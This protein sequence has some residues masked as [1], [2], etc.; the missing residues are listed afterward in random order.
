M[1]GWI[2]LHRDIM[3]H[4][5][6]EDKPFSKGQAFID[7]LLLT[8]AS[9]KK[10]LYRGEIVELKRGDVNRSIQ[11]LSIRWG[12][13][14]GKTKRFLNILET[15][16]MITV[17]SDTKRTV[18]TVENYSRYQDRRTVDDTANDTTDGHQTVQQA[19]IPKKVKKVKNVKNN[20]NNIYYGEFENVALS[21][22][23]LEKLKERFPYDWQERIE[24][25]SAY[26][27]STG[28][29]YKSHYA[30]ILNWAR[31]EKTGEGKESHKPD[32]MDL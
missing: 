28:K 29:R 17:K 11:E 23:E 4:W 18:I 8:D 13:S 19:D 26:M 20:I 15:D 24:R 1:A 3:K 22:E 7:L 10:K 30:T 27:K 5:L 12:W 25:L 21:E 9:D 31:K 6:W 16:G 2:K 14:R 32:F